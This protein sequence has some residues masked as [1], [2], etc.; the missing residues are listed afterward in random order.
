MNRPVLSA[1]A[2]RTMLLPPGAGAG[3]KTV[4]ASSWRGTRS[5]NSL[6]LT[7]EPRL[8][9]PVARAGTKSVTACIASSVSAWGILEA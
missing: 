8:L 1:D 9:L 2:V 5:G 6:D 7:Q 3:T 4:T